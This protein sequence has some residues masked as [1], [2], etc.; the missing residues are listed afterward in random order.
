MTDD[1]LLSYLKKH[2]FYDIASII[3]ILETKIIITNEHINVLNIESIFLNNNYKIISI[4]QQYGY[5]FSNDEL[6]KLSINDIRIVPYIP[7]DNI[8]IVYN[9]LI[10]NNK[11]ILRY[12]PENKRTYDICINSISMNGLML[13]YVPEN[14]KTYEICKTA[15]IQ[16]GRC[17]LFVP[18]NIKIKNYIF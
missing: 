10:K 9:Y 2:Y 15:V 8:D 7:D 11:H 12:I 1:K 3:K 16:N 5:I 6:I 14:M 13:E 17:L 4:F 18:N